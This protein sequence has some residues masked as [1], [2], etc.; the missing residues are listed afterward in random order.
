MSIRVYRG[1]HR[2]TGG[3]TFGFRTIPWIFFGLGLLFSAIWP[4]FP[5]DRQDSLS[6]FLILFLF[7]AT[8]A[9]AFIWW[10]MA[11]AATY[12]VVS[13]G[14]SFSFLAINSATG[15]I[16]GD[17][18]YTYRLGIQLFHV[19]F[20]SPLI[21]SSVSYLGIVLSRRI[22][23]AVIMSPLTAAFISLGLLLVVESLFA[24]AGYFQWL[25]KPENYS[26]LGINPVQF[27]IVSFFIL[28]SIMLLSSQN[29]KNDRYSTKFPYLTYMWIFLFAV[30]C[31]Q[32]LSNN[33]SAFLIPFLIMAYS[34]VIFAYK[35]I[36]ER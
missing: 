1:P 24:N 33:I 26:I 15:F 17:V 2:D 27:Q 28:L 4:I 18:Q 32:F 21:W 29:A 12:L 6:L 11:W 35:T 31:A 13:L 3:P 30:Y 36:R 10:G 16:F 8:T 23:R 19:P 9:H 14:L 25:P 22:T 5:Q 7:I 34:I 20:S